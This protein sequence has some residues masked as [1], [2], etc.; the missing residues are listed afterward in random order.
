M[1]YSAKKRQFVMWCHLD[2]SENT[3]VNTWANYVFRRAGVAVAD[4]PQGPF[5]PLRALRP[6]GLESLDINIF[7]DH[8]GRSHLQQP[9]ASTG[10]P[11]VYIIRACTK[12]T[13]LG[14]SKLND[15]LTMTEG[16]I[17]SKV[18]AKV[19]G[20]VLFRDPINGALY[21]IASGVHGWEPGRMHAFREGQRRRSRVLTGKRSRI[22]PCTLAASSANPLQCSPKRTKNRPALPSIPVTTGLWTS[23]QRLNALALSA[24]M[25]SSSSAGPPSGRFNQKYNVYIGKLLTWEHT[26]L[27]FV[28]VHCRSSSPQ[29]ATTETFHYSLS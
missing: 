12:N 10:A 23:A 20:P 2:V 14:I 7:V 21:L 1:V 5:K 19:E 15:D 22:P 13:F 11:N 28:Y 8:W 3:A 6:N 17:V 16:G 25:S 26:R 24:P 18:K 9:E 29:R 4:A 27:P